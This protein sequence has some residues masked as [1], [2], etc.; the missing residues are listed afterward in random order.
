MPRLKFQRRA[1]AGRGA[2]GAE[3]GSR[4]KARFV[5]ER[6]RHGAQPAHSLNADGNAEKRGTSI[7]G[8]PLTSRQHRRDD[9]RAGMN[10]TALEC[11]VEIFAM[12]RRAV[13]QRCG[14][15]A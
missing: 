10:R 14:G 11:V 9:D 12:D 1:D 13:D 6:R 15:G 5:G 3:H 7:Q 8:V 2:H 4:M